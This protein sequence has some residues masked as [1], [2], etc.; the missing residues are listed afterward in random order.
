MVLGHSLVGHA[1]MIAA[2]LFEDRAPDGIVAYAPN[3]WTPALEPSRRLRALKTA[4][5]AGW[6]ALA[7]ATGYFDTARYG[8]GR[9]PMAE[10]YVHQFQ[11]MWRADRLGGGG[12]DYEAALARAQVDVLAF[13][14]RNDRLFATPASVERFVALSRGADVEHHVLDGPDAPDHM[15]FVT[16]PRSESLW[17][18]TASWILKRSGA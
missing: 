6:A 16:D 2:G 3:L 4:T 18:Q 1:A 7:R 9:T 8:L 12:D 11:A 17:Q 13:S 10:P 5:L 14:S 15:G